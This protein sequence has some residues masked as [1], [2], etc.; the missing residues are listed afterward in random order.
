MAGHNQARPMQKPDGRAG[1]IPA[2]KVLR[3]RERVAVAQELRKRL[4]LEPS[5]AQ[6]ARDEGLSLRAVRSI[7]NFERYKWVRP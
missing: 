5:L 1:D 6:I 7:V 4:T 3:I 2:D